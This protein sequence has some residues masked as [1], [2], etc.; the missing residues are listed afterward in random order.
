MFGVCALTTVEKLF[1]K[2]YKKVILFVVLWLS[3]IVSVL[4]YRLPLQLYYY[5]GGVPGCVLGFCV[6]VLVVAVVIVVS[7]V[8]L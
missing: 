2:I 6:I 1:L 4:G 7:V 5:W 3:V 8:F